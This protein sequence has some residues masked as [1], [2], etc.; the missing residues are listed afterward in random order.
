[1][2]ISKNIIPALRMFSDR[3]AVVVIGTVRYILRPLNVRTNIG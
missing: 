1:M 2:P 3:L